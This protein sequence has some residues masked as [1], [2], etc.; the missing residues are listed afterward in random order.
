MNVINKYKFIIVV[1]VIY[2]FMFVNHYLT[3]LLLVILFQIFISVNMYKRIKGIFKFEKDICVRG[4]VLELREITGKLTRYF[5][6]EFIVEFEWENK[7]IRTNYRFNALFKPKYENKIVD[8]WIDESNP[9]N[10]VVT[11][12][13]VFK[14]R[15]YILLDFVVVVIVL[16]VVDYFLLLKML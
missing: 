12:S 6:Y 1:G 9:E 11:E 13:A 15:W 7:K 4:I 8:V 10:S 2:T 16:S 14:N 3:V 5:K